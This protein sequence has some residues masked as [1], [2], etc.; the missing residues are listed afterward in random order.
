LIVL[1]VFLI[2]SANN[3]NTQLAWPILGGLRFSDINCALLIEAAA[4]LNIV[5]NTAIRML[6]N[7]RSRAVSQAQALNAEIE[8][9][10]IELLKSHPEI[11]ATIAGESRCLR[12]IFRNVIQEMVNKLA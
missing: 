2:R 7:L 8:S 10:N 1:I 3:A 11:S 6:E 4:S 12:L 5:K 9:E